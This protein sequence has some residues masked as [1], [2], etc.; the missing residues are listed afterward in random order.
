VAGAALCVVVLLGLVA[1][2]ALTAQF[3]LTTPEPL[4]AYA[5]VFERLRARMTAQDRVYFSFAHPF[6]SYFGLTAKSAMFFG[7]PALVDYQASISRRYADLFM[8]MKVGASTW[9]PTAFVS[10][11]AGGTPPGFNRRLLDLA[12][13][14][15]LL[16][17]TS[18]DNTTAVLQPTVR[19]LEDDGDVRLYENPAALPRARWVPRVEVIPDPRA[20]LERLAHGAQDPRDVALVEAPVPSGPGGAGAGTA[21]GTTA[22]IRNEPEHVVVRVDAPAAGFLVLAD[23]YFPGWT[24]TVNGA[25]RPIVRADYVFRLVAVPAGE[26][27]VEFRFASRTLRLG[28]WISGITLLGMA[29][30]LAVSVARRRRAPRWIGAEVRA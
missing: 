9:A 4:R 16:A 29:G 8:M 25:P 23:Q 5:D 15:Y 27:V 28:A 17:E 20:L 30:A 18:V 12:A 2:P 14:R 22:F 21:R 26:S 24:A 7:V 19:V 3:L 11:Q 6:V 10:N 13:G 1:T